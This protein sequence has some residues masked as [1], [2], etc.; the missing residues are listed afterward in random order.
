VE[1][2]ALDT[3]LRRIKELEG[4]QQEWKEEKKKLEEKVATLMAH[5]SLVTASDKGARP[6]LVVAQGDPNDP[7]LFKDAGQDINDLKPGEL[8]KILGKEEA[9]RVEDQVGIVEAIIKNAEAAADKN[10]KAAEKAVKEAEEQMEAFNK[11][12]DPEAAEK[13][14]EKLGK[15]ARGEAVP[16]VEN[17]VDTDLDI[18]V[19]PVEA[20]EKKVEAATKKVKRVEAEVEAAAKKVKRVEAEVEAL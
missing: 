5:G 1:T 6:S 11:A 13:Q 18:D 8:A 4:K 16:A 19:G 12:K 3:A 15:V 17:D 14:V 7:A 20:A 9:R 10:V 2:I